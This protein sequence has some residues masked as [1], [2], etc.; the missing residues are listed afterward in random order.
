MKLCMRV[1][2]RVIRFSNIRRDYNKS[3]S[4]WKQSLFCPVRQASTGCLTKANSKK[5]N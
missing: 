1:C 2:V 3:C 4:K 5:I